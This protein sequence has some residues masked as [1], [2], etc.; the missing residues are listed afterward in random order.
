MIKKERY[1]TTELK[2]LRSLNKRMHLPVKEK[3][4]YMNL[5]KGLTGEQQFD[6]WSSKLT[7]K[8]L[9]LND[10]QLEVNHTHFQI[11]SIF[12]CPETIYLFEVKNYEG[13]FYIKGDEWY[14]IKGME[15]KNPLLQLKKSESLLRQ[16]FYHLPY[17]TS[18]KS[19]LVFI[20]PEFTLY[21][22]SPN[23]PIVLPTQMNRFK[24][25]WDKKHIRLTS[26]EQAIAEKLLSFIWMN[27]PSLI[28]LRTTWI[29]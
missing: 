26:K 14:T 13:E 4:Y 20:N 3:K 29:N 6:K 1:E 8:P 9:I 11:D 5:E 15:I 19:Y 24:K 7:S 12:I 22:A 28:Y 10:L 17:N 23:L 2:C 21:H 18:I 25:K 16:I 27:P